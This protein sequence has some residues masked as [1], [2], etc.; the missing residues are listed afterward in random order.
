MTDGAK[1]VSWRAQESPQWEEWISEAFAAF[2][3][4][5]SGHLSQAALTAMLCGEV[6]QARPHTSHP[7]A[8]PIFALVLLLYSE[9]HLGSGEDKGV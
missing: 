3:V 5:G 4:D 9:A 1:A 6:C 8:F 2:D 7:E